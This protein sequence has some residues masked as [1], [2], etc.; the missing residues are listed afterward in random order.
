MTAKIQKF[1]SGLR[2]DTESEYL[3][4]E[5]IDVDTVNVDFSNDTYSLGRISASNIESCTALPGQV[6]RANENG[7][8][9]WVDP[10]EL[11]MENDKELREKYPSLEIAWENVLKAIHEYELVKKMVK[12]H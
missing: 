7:Q 12:D 5:W 8:T 4:G 10:S 9:E 3:A 11:F 1:G 2:V 6:L